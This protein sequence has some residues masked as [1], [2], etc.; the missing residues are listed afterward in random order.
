M[1]KTPPDNRLEGTTPIRQAQLV[2]LGIL[3]EIDRVCKKHN[4]TYWLAHG[5]LLGA[6]RKN[7]F[8][9]WDDD[10]DIE[11]PREDFDVL[12][13][14]PRSEFSEHI[15][16]DSTSEVEG[17]F[18]CKVKDRYSK[19]IDGNIPDS[20]KAFNTIFIDIFPVKKFHF[21]RKVLSRIRML[22]PP[23]TPPS[24]KNAKTLSKKIK[25]LL[26]N[27][28][29]YVLTYSG[30]QFLIKGLS[31]LGPKNVWAYDLKRP[32]HYHF[33]DSWIFPLN[34]IKFEDSYFPI[35]A[36]S[37]KILAT[38]YGKNF[39]TPLQ[40]NHHLNEDIFPTTPCKHP[41]ARD[42][43]KDFPETKKD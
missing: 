42:W 27:V 24:I 11:M 26:V 38:M 20:D 41:E 10:L 22:I 9:P 13:N 15:F 12:I 5:T 2:M 30:L 18:Y 37:E 28:L 4:L 3:K 14:L 33:Y 25:R 8:I 31:L 17:D 23:Y 32:R 40:D 36:H 34:Q 43:Y 1:Q 35:P 7:C 39:M 29:Y 19:R 16:L 6:Y 21:M